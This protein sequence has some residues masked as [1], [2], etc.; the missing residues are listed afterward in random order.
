MFLKIY[1]V[2]VNIFV[3]AFLARWARAMVTNYDRL[4]MHEK[5]RTVA[6][7]VATMVAIA[8]LM[9]A[10]TLSAAIWIPVSLH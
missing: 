4:P 2:V 1:A 9:S 6:V 3:A 8:M 7:T 5:D 10:A